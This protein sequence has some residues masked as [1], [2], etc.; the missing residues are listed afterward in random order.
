[1]AFILL[2]AL[3]YGAMPILAKVA[4]AEGL[5]PAGL[6]AYR[7]LVAS[8]LFSVTAPRDAP[9]LPW[10]RRLVL[11][12]LGDV[13]FGNSL[14]YFKALET[15]P[16]SVVAFLLYTYPVLVTLLSGLAGLDPLTPSGLASAALAF[17][18]AALTVGSIPGGSSGSGVAFSLTAAL[19]YSVYVVLAGRF[20]AGTPSEAAAR[21]VAQACAVFFLLWAAL[22]GHLAAPPS[23]RAWGATLGIA[24]ACT[25]VALRAFLA[26]LARVGPSRAAVASA[27]EVLVTVILASLFLGETVGARQW[28]G[29]ILILGAV[30]LHNVGRLRQTGGAPASGAGTTDDGG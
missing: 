3:A 27:L 5:R 30:A 1:M 20:A 15:T 4:Y 24:V 12:G 14:A 18:G 29:G 6:L 17:L 28:A 16:A 7:F 11:W 19:V 2:S 13:F 10:G 23:A 26:G 21:H 9:A 22:E 8:A 25:V